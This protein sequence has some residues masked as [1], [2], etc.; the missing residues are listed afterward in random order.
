MSLQTLAPPSD[1]AELAPHAPLGATLLVEPG[2]ALDSLD[3]AERSALID[4]AYDEYCDLAEAGVAPDPDEFCDRFPAFRTSLAKL[5]Q[6]HIELER[7]SDLSGKISVTWP[8]PGESFL[9]FQLGNVLG[10]GTFARAY[11][12]AE[13]DVGGRLVAL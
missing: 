9:G 10:Q 11:V 8:E 12:A 6:A 2:S 4:R 13:T 5:L 7:E 1:I 3:P